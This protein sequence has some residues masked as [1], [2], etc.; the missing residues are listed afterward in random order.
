MAKEKNEIVAFKS[1]EIAKMDPKEIMSL[2]HENLGGQ[3][4]R[5]FELERIK[6]PGAGGKVWELTD[7][8]GDVQGV[9]YFDA[10][11]LH[12]RDGRNYYKDDYNDEGEK[13]PPDC[14]SDDLTNGIGN[15]GGKCHACKF[16]QFKTAQ[17]GKGQACK[18]VNLL[19][20]A[21]PG[22]IIPKLLSLPPTSLASFR[23]YTMQL[24]NRRASY[25]NVLTRF[26]LA[27]VAGPKGPV[28]VCVPKLIARLDPEDCKAIEYM[29]AGLKP[30]FYAARVDDADNYEAPI[31]ADHGPLD[32]EDDGEAGF[33]TE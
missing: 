2:I 10:V 30:I 21:Q 23:K 18:Q 24:V 3:Q 1:Y 4:L 31:D 16:A 20:L 12:K 13:S 19:F 33:T 6:I 14:Y 26:T 11:I 8:A 25:F 9:S 5:H 22:D 27:Q 15:P 7:E 32:S 28:A 17:N 29:R